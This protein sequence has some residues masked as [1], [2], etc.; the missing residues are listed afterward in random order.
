MAT[1]IYVPKL[2]MT[3]T[4]GTVAEWHIPDG[5]EVKAGESIFRLETEKIEF[6]VEAEGPGIVR[7]VVPEGTTLECGAVVAYVLAP[8]EA[9][10]PG[11]LLAASAEAVTA[12]TAVGASTSTPLAQDG[13][14]VAASPA[15]RRLA[16]DRGIPIAA[17]TGT[18]PGGRVTEDDVARY[19]PPVG[20]PP[21][22]AQPGAGEVAASPIARRLAEQLGVDLAQVKGTGPGGRITKEDVEAAASPQPSPT[23]QRGT[24]ATSTDAAAAQVIP[25]RGVR[26][27][28]FERMTASLQTMAQLTLA[29]EVAM[30]DAVRLRASL[31]EEWAAGGIRPSHT[32]LVIRAVAKALAEHRSFNAEVRA[33]G[34]HLLPDIHIGMAV[35]TDA[36]LMVP[37][38][39]H[40]DR[41]SLKEIAVEARRLA[42]G[43]RAGRL[44]PDDYAGGAFSVTAL[45]M[46]GV[47]FFTPIINPP[48]VAILGVGRIHDTTAW[49]GDRP[50]KRQAMTLSLTWDHRVNDGAP[51]ADFA[52]A[53]KALLESPYRLLV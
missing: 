21:A 13:G 25:I 7:H 19:Q 51:A 16:E 34:I 39:R 22:A 3:M 12:V 52:G 8:G 53:V 20:P 35:S 42:E 24:L 11:A 31:I 5:G 49:E 1:E 4:E 38:I 18:G 45:G 9:M 30:D 36:G 47:D 28:I 15:A 41:F 44:G 6:E 23:V 40:A 37:V 10:P 2:G 29:M 26:K 14:R 50:V 32:D 46:Y 43:A 48:N 27:V 17:V 33:D